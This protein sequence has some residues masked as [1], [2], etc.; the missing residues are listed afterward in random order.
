MTRPLRV[1]HLIKGLGR[2][3]AEGLLAE[4]LR[5]ADRERFTYAYGYFH[6]QKSA[7]V[8]E[9]Q[10]EGSEVAR[11]TALTAGGMLLQTAPVARFFRRWQ[12]DLV[13]C[14][15]PLAGVVGR[16]AARRAGGIPVV[17][18]QHNLP[19]RYHPLTRL[20]ERATW[21]LQRHVI[22]VS[23]EVA[24]AICRR[25]P[26]P[27]PV[28]VVPN[29]VDVGRFRPAA[30][31][32]EAARS[33]LDLGDCDGVVG[34]VAVFRPQK[35]LDRWLRVARRVHEALPRSRFVLVGDGPGRGAL[36]AL[37]RRLG[38]ADV[39]RFT[40]LQPDV[41]PFLA[42]MD[43]FL[44]SSVYEGLPVAALEA[45]AAGLP[46]VSTGVGGVREA[47][48]DGECGRL[49]AGDQ[50][51]DLAAA[52]I[53]LLRQPQ[54]RERMGRAARRRAETRFGIESMQRRLES[55]YRGVLPGGAEPDQL[56]TR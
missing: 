28:T 15:L 7:L 56:S 55:I 41:E 42:A 17:Y 21:R 54:T 52:V 37:S 36:E 5:V 12:P 2:G 20:A 8:S 22:A 51:S 19:E 47:V 49:I 30:E 29:G 44:L 3:G 40:G 43:L 35:G 25:L 45:M 53:D 31:R 46:I 48:V 9:L 16:L 1:F 32:R 13:H 39:V 26:G 38:L 24:A 50:D 33:R 34:T 10:G 11:F 14:H 27:V 6:P 23:E 4:G 18:T